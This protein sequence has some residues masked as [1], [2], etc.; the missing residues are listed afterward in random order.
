MSFGLIFFLI[1]IK[2]IQ[3]MLVSEPFTLS[4][5]TINKK[6]RKNHFSFKKQEEYILNSKESFF[7]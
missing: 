3:E 1:I 4:Y 2:E 7:P 6:E 5:K